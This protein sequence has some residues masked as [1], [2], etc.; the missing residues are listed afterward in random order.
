M[1]I[2]QKEHTKKSHSA[3]K[4]I[5]LRK[6]RTCLGNK[7]AVFFSFFAILLISAFVMLY[8]FRP[9]ASLREDAGSAKSK[10]LSVNSFF[11]TINTGFMEQM[12]KT[13][14][15][16][17]FS[18][19]SN[20]SNIKYNSDLNKTF[21]ELILNG[22]INNNPVVLME[23]F[24]VSHIINNLSFLSYKH[25]GI[26]TNISFSR[27]CLNQ[28]VPWYVNIFFNVTYNI[29]KDKINFNITQQKKYNISI[30]GLN[31]PL[32][33]ANGFHRRIYATN[34]SNWTIEN[35]TIF[36]ASQR[37]R[38]RR[39]SPSY[40]LRLMNKSLPSDYGIESILN[41][42]VV[43][44]A[45]YSY[46]DY[47]FWNKSVNCSNAVLFNITT[48]LIPDSHKQILFDTFH[49]GYYNITNENWEVFCQP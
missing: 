1:E 18:I 14:A 6:K 21:S 26:K 8:S 37:Y 39:G 9:S 24:S 5:C 16:R 3:T 29:T 7:R 19:M 45:N 25:M 10:V 41:A 13:S 46:V 43:G 32:F 49:I 30:I 15:V 27:F 4:R 47:M 20:K 44:I 23:N 33:E 28:S 31:D 22:T 42:S 40:L 36:Y 17:A 38:A 11:K 48:S 34:I 2:R 12:I 35:F